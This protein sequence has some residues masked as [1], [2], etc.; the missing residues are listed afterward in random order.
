MA[1]AIIVDGLVTVKITPYG[2]AKSSLGYTRN[3]VDITFEGFFLDIMGDENGG[4]D[5]P[6][7]DVQ[8]L[9]EVAR[10]R[11]ELT[12]WDTALA[13]NVMERH[14]QSAAGVPVLSPGQ[15]LINQDN[16]YLAL[17]L[18]SASR[19]YTFPKVFPRNAIELNKGT[20]FSTF[21][22]EFEAHRFGAT[23]TLYSIA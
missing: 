20:K 10:V 14:Y 8:Y 6:P 22:C 23:G 15:T 3:G 13:L 11:C 17:E 21:T 2:G 5:G 1:I 18:T 7:I 4:D 19:T 16:G 9:G 12:K